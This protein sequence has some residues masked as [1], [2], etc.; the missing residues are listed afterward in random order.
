MSSNSEGVE[1]GVDSGDAA[2][3]TRIGQSSCLTPVATCGLGIGVR[4]AMFA[5]LWW[6]LAE[7]KTDSWLL[8]IPV[9]LA[10]TV[11]SIRLQPTAVRPTRLTSALRL[12]L[13]FVDRS[14]V[15]GVDVARRA[16]SLNIAPQAISYSTLLKHQSARVLFAGCV[17]LMP[18]TLAMDMDG[19]RLLI[20]TLDSRGPLVAELSRLEHR[21]AAVFGE[22]LPTEKST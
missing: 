3:K 2:S 6:I 11:A 9:V 13:F 10:A 5:S 16:V 18:G 12:G 7:G 17:S 20:H 1:S 22:R 15:A 4:L 8:G 14:L 21:I 19:S